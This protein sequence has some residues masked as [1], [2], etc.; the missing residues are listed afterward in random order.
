MSR[1]PTATLALACLTAITLV[2]TD[3]PVPESV[4]A[5]LLENDAVRVVRAVERMKRTPETF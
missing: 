5:Q 2:E 1:H 3:Q 4:I